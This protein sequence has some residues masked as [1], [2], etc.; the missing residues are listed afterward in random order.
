MHGVIFD[1][2][3]LSPN[4][5]GQLTVAVAEHCEAWP[6]AR[7]SSLEAFSHAWNV[8]ASYG[9][10][11][12][13]GGSGRARRPLHLTGLSAEGAADGGLAPVK[14]RTAFEGCCPCPSRV[15]QRRE[16]TGLAAQWRK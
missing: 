13:C 2:V 4:Q 3:I 9:T 15:L 11:G 6:R 5:G 8:P 12:R 7:P 1:V 10:S 14:G 16:Y